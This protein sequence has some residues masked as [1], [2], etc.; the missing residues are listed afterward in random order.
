M[1]EVMRPIYSEKIIELLHWEVA[2]IKE[3]VL[4]RG[5]VK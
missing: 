1:R 2:S 5:K 3:N 4:Q